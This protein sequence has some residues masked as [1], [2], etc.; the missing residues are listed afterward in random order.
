MQKVGEAL[1]FPEGLDYASALCLA[2]GKERKPKASGL[3]THQQG[4]SG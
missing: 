4:G 1:I 2:V 3:G